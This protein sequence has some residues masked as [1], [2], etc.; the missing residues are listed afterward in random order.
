MD[1]QQTIFN[2]AQ[3]AP[4][5]LIAIVVHE[6]AHGRM[7]LYFGDTTAKDA[8]RLTLNPSAHIDPMGTI[9]FPL[10]GALMQWA[11]IGWARP[12]PVNPRNFRSYRKAIFWVSFAGPLS[13]FI[14]GVISAFLFGLVVA[15]IPHTFTYFTVL[16]YMLKYSVFINFLLGSFNLIPLPPLDGSR[17]VSAFLKGET[18]RKYEELSR[19]TPVIFL[20]V[21]ALSIMGIPT[22]GLILGPVIGF[23]EKLTMYFSYLLG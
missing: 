22:I 1:I 6:W 17:M 15:Y 2:I 10:M 11:V 5:F 13:N 19:L 23:G 8:D 3:S 16:L 12:V 9:F 14:L 21:I 4:G 20:V 7:A 18:Q